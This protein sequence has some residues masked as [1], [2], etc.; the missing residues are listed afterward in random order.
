VLFGR[1][2][3]DRFAVFKIDA[4]T[5]DT[6]FLYSLFQV[7]GLNVNLNFKA[8]SVAPD[9]RTFYQSGSK[10]DGGVQTRQ[11]KRGVLRTAEGR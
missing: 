7:N 3:K 6:T 10:W 2:M 4:T 5:S 11:P 1:D 9:G 8:P